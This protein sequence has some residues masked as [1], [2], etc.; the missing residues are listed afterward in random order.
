MKIAAA[1]SL[2][3]PVR[4][5]HRLLAHRVCTACSSCHYAC[6]GAGADK[7]AREKNRWQWTPLHVAAANGH[8]ECVEALLG[9]RRAD[10]QE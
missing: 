2:P 8:K 7:D 1:S 9:N 6:L 4:I 3:L 10:R 5:A